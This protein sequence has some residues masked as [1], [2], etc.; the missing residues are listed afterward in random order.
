M[1]VVLCLQNKKLSD[2]CFTVILHVPIDGMGQ[3][4]VWSR[5][6]YC[7]HAP[8]LVG[9]DCRRDE[10]RAQDKP[11]LPPFLSQGKPWLHQTEASHCLSKRPVCVEHRALS[12]WHTVAN[13]TAPYPALFTSDLREA[14]REK[15]VLHSPCSKPACPL[16]DF[17]RDESRWG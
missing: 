9:Q 3:K 7:A 8:L 6:R 12:R 16:P 2:L 14:F 1:Y 13:W 5:P 11:S 17:A 15:W 10:G 4:P